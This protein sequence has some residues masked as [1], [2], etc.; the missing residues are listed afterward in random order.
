MNFYQPYQLVSEKFG[1]YHAGIFLLDEN[2]EYALLRASDSEGGKRMLERQ[3]K[4]NRIRT[5]S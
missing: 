3:H 1:Y 2:Q 5:A 4:L